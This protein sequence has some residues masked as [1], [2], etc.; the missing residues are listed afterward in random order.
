[1]HV[2]MWIFSSLCRLSSL[3]RSGLLPAGHLRGW[4]KAAAWD[5]AR[6]YGRQA[7]RQ[8]QVSLPFVLSPVITCVDRDRI[9]SVCRVESA[10]RSL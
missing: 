2:D 10:T 5:W 8:W 6:K 9:K 4:S 3:L 1:M 7:R